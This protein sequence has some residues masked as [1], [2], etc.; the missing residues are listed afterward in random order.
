MKTIYVLT[1]GEYSDYHII[2]VYSTKELAEKEQFVH[3]KSRIEEYYL[4]F[5]SDYPP[6]MK[7]WQVFVKNNIVYDICQIHPFSQPWEH[8]WGDGEYSTYCWAEDKEH[9]HKIT[10]DRYYQFLARKAGIAQ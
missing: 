8:Q 3:P 1:E 4:D 5:V 2:G 6:G 7:A 10:L 9:A